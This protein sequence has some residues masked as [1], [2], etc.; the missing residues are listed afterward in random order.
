MNFYAELQ[1]SFAQVATLSTGQRAELAVS[2][3]DVAGADGQAVIS[4][5]IWQYTVASRPTTR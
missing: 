4:L 3:R 1:L 2:I 5:A